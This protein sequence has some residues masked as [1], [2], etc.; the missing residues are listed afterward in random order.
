VCSITKWARFI[1]GMGVM[2]LAIALFFTIRI[3]LGFVF[4]SFVFFFLDN[5]GKLKTD[6][7]C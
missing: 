7:K 4:I 1:Q 5:N 3:Q 2:F 6:T